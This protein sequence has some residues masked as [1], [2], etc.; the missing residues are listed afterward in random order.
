M[1]ILFVVDKYDEEGILAY[2]FDHDASYDVMIRARKIMQRGRMNRGFTFANPELKTA[3]VVIGPTTSGKQ[4]VNTLSHE[5]RHL[6]DAIAKSIGY[7]LDG[8]GA[9]YLTGDTTMALI[10][11]ICEL[12]CD[13]CR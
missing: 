2:L 11:T 1:D 13:K 12:G 6:A 9:A 10:E 8:E 3:L 7:R 4:F 5:I